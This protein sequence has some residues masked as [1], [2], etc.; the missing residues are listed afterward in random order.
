MKHAI[1]FYTPGCGEAPK[2]FGCATYGMASV[3]D[4]YDDCTRKF[5]LEPESLLFCGEY[6]T[7]LDQIKKIHVPHLKAAIV[8]FGNVGGENTFVHELKT[9]VRCPVVGGGAAMDP[10]TGAGGLIAGGG[11]VNVLLITD[12]RL[13]VEAAHCCIHR[14]KIGRYRLTLQ[15]PRTLLKINGMDAKTFLEQKKKGLGLKATDFEHLTFS[16][17]SGVNAHLSLENGQIKSG[18]DL[19]PEMELCYVNHKDVYG[20]IAEFY[21]DDENTL[22]FGC[23]GLRGILDQ[24]ISTR[25]M[26]LFLFGEVCDLGETAEFG[27]LMLSKLRFIQDGTV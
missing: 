8:L 22:V 10:K 24:D 2:G 26:G 3:C 1:R 14:E 23:A 4:V 12:P 5:P 7:V 21:E 17:G 15:D 16:D 27:N 11:Q 18:R 20:Q 19:T 13:R 9:I 6:Q 25:A